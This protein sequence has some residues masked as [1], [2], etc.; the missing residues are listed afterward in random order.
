MEIADFDFKDTQL[1]RIAGKDFLFTNWRIRKESVPPSL[2]YIYEIADGDGDGCICRVAKGIMVNHWGTITGKEP[3][4]EVPYYPEYGSEEYEGCYGDRPETLEDY[5]TGNYESPDDSEA[6]DGELLLREGQQYVAEFIRDYQCKSLDEDI[7]DTFNSMPLESCSITFAKHKE[8]EKDRVQITLIP[9]QDIRTIEVLDQFREQ[10]FIRDEGGFN[11]VEEKGWVVL[12]VYDQQ[13]YT[14]P[15]Y[16]ESAES[17][18]YIR[19]VFTGCRETAEAYRKALEEKDRRNAE[20]TGEAP[21]RYY[22]VN[23]YPLYH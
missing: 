9:S 12:E 23:G 5:L 8:G 19:R 11:P 13:E 7:Q 4:P 20:E 6:P 16:Y 22:E 2:P 18:R 14:E 1:L 17:A 15:K 21:T 3:L 10:G